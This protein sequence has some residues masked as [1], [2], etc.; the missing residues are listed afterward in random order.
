M[1][2]QLYIEIQYKKMDAI[3]LGILSLILFVA[4]VLASRYIND[5]ISASDIPMNGFQKAFMIYGFP[6]GGLLGFGLAGWK[7]NVARKIE[8]SN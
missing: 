7:W 2:E 4:G 8:N 1:N 3:A 5:M 6:C